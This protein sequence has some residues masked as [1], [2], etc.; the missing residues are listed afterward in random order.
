MQIDIILLNGPW[1]VCAAHEV[2]NGREKGIEVR[3]IR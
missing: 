2:F 1:K 3:A